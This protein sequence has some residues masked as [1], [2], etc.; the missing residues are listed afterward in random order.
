MSRAILVLALS[1]LV[2][3]P[4]QADPDCAPSQQVFTFGE[5]MMGHEAQGFMDITNNSSEVLEIDVHVDSPHFSHGGYHVWIPPGETRPLRPNFHPQAGGYLEAV[6]T[7]GNDICTDVLLRGTGLAR[8][9]AVEPDFLDFGIVPLG[10]TA[11]R[12][13]VLTNDG[14][15]EIPIEA[16]T[17]SPVLAVIGPS[18]DLAPGDSFSYEVRFSPNGPGAFTG[19]IDWG[20]W[21][22]T[23]AELNFVGEGDINMEPGQNR[24]GVFFDTDYTELIH[25]NDGSAEFLTGYLVLT[26]PEPFAGVTAWELSASVA[27]SAYILGWDIQGDFINAGQN[28]QLIIGLGGDPLPPSSDV[29]LA[30]CEIYVA[31]APDE[32]I[33]VQLGPV[34]NPTIPGRMAWIPAAEGSEPLV[35]QPFTGVEAVAW[36]KTGGLSPEPDPLPRVKTRILG[37]VPNPFNPSTEIRFAVAQDGPATLQI[38]DLN[39]RLVRTLVDDHL[40]AGPQVRVWD[41]RDDTGRRMASGA[42][43]VRLEAGGEVAARKVMLLK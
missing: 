37:N 33:A 30:S 14:D 24:V 28:G 22:P 15:V 39:G 21:Y 1:L 7:L 16:G 41:G 42:Y 20:A 36:I 5:V 38:F 11:L 35:M 13:V 25:Y 4:A 2:G 34:W 8:S 17:L 9:C 10:E 31:E 43:Y 12:T 18:G 27:G 40:T 26:E 3:W 29:L 19:N 23:C 32:L 6:M